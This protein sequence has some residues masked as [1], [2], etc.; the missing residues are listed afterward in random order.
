MQ[1]V[2]IRYQV[3][4]PTILLSRPPR[5]IISQCSSQF[6]KNV[7]QKIFAVHVSAHFF[8]AYIS[9][10]NATN[11]R[12]NVPCVPSILGKLRKPP[13][14]NN[15]KCQEHSPTPCHSKIPAT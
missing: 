15:P 11:N 2:V 10:G 4:M 12:I 8:H 9:R 6:K 7:I 3:V 5:P 13:S 1:D 14:K